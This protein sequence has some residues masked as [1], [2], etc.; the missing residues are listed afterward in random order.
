MDH[1]TVTFGVNKL[2][3][4]LAFPQ[5]DARQDRDGFEP[6]D[7]LETVL[8]SIMYL[9]YKG[10]WLKGSA[11]HKKY[12]PTMYDTLFTIL[13]RCL[14]GKNSGI[15]TTTHPMA[16]LFQGVAED[17]HYDYAQLIFSDLFEMVTTTK[18]KKMMK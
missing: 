7:D 4:I 8:A 9:G 3:E 5:A 15:D 14:T 6:F 2:R 10:A 12:L 11:F 1:F 16:L 17:R 13:N 18:R